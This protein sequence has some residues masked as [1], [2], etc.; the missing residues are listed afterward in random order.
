MILIILAVIVLLLL[1]LTM[2]LWGVNSFDIAGVFILAASIMLSGAYLFSLNKVLK[3]MMNDGR[4]SVLTL[5]DKGV[6]IRKGDT[7]T[8][9]IGWPDVAVVKQYRESLN[10]VSADQT[11]FVISADKRYADQ[12]LAWIRENQPGVD[13][14]I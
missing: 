12:I 10:F 3:P 1:I 7:Q 9:R 2:V 11:G 5:D 13:L 14:R 8:L 4:T 6:E